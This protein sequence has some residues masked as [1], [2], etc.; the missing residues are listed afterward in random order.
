MECMRATSFVWST[1]EGTRW[2]A[3]TCQLPGPYVAGSL[4]VCVH[5]ASNWSFSPLR[6]KVPYQLSLY[7]QHHAEGLVFRRLNLA[8]IT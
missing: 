3:L 7:L 5:L 8:Y 6:A 4:A 2:A 1:E